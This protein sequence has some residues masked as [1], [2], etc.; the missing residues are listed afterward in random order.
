MILS[1]NIL[2]PTEAKPYFTKI[3]RLN[4]VRDFDDVIDWTQKDNNQKQE[5][6]NSQISTDNPVLRERS[7][8]S[9]APTTTF[10]R[11]ISQRTEAPVATVSTDATVRIEKRD[12]AAAT[13]TSMATSE[14]PSPPSTDEPKEEKK[15]WDDVKEVTDKMTENE[16]NLEEFGEGISDL[17]KKIKNKMTNKKCKTCTKCL[18]KWDLMRLG[19]KEG[20]ERSGAKYISPYRRNTPMCLLNERHHGGYMQPASGKSSLS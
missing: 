16:E 17:F 7:I 9:E 8:S 1:Q 6:K 5:P 19:E 13:A 14:M 12:T 15:R 11:I 3:H 20:D 10:Y 2:P 18:G 4:S